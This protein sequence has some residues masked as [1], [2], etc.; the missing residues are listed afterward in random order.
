[1]D[2]KKFIKKA[3]LQS[4]MVLNEYSSIMIPA[5]ITLGSAGILYP[6]FVEGFL[7]FNTVLFVTLFLLGKF[8]ERIK[9][10]GYYDILLASIS[11]ILAFT[12]FQ[13]LTFLFVASGILVLGFAI[14]TIFWS[15]MEIKCAS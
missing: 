14:F 9:L 15:T 11:V 1:M 12:Y 2:A 4:K 8:F 5:F 13:K 6:Y 7:I 3:V 10:K